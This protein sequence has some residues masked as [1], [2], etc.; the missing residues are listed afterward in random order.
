MIIVLLFLASDHAI[1]DGFY[2]RC[3]ILFDK[4]AEA[5]IDRSLQKT[6]NAQIVR[7]L[8]LGISD[9]VRILLVDPA[10][11]TITYFLACI[12]A[13][14]NHSNVTFFQTFSNPFIKFI[15]YTSDSSDTVRKILAT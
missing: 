9:I 4:F 7:F 11:Q 14:V 15:S 6:H 5:L 1:R 13:V 3:L 2:Q 8:F 10:D 12:Y